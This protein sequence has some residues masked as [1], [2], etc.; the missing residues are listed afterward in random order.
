MAFREF[1]LVGDSIAQGFVD[2]EGRGWYGRFAQRVV[3]AY[4][5]Q[6]SFHNA[7]QG[8]DCVIDAYHRLSVEAVQRGGDFLIL[9]VGSNDVVRWKEPDAQLSLAPELSAVTWHWMLGVAKKNYRRILVCGCLPAVEARYPQPGFED[10]PYYRFNAD[11]VAYN[12]MLEGQCAKAGVPFLPL[13]DMF[14]GCDDLFFDG[15][16]PNGEGHAMIAEAVYA[17]V[18]EL[19]WF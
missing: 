9:A 8:G 19:G 11:L 15:C 5:A 10:M 2:E 16:H 17:R 3:E 4:P 18:V 6:F 1:A 12:T 13:F 7:S 14:D